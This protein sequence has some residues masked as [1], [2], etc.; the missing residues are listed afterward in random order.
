MD[1]TPPLYIIMGVSGAGKTT[2][3]RALAAALG[4]DFYDGDDFHPP[5]NVARMSAGLPLDDT[6]RAPWLASLVTLL[7]EHSSRGAPV[8]LACSALK[9]TYRDQLNVADTVRFVYL[10][11]DA[12]LLRHRLEQRSGH[13]MQPNMLASQ[14]ASLE[15]PDREEALWVSF[16]QPPAAIVDAILAAG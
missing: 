12:E 3:G 4:C 1:D 11:G 10:N 16:D 5:A 6:D 2:V 9:R 7:R 8:V 14:L 15:P 13:Y